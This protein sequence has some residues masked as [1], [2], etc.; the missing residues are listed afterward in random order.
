MSA[1]LQKRVQ[2]LENGRKEPERPAFGVIHIRE[3]ECAGEAWRAEY[4]EAPEPEL[5]V[6]LI[7]FDFLFRPGEALDRKTGQRFAAAGPR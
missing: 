3:N 5:L 4:G 6:G 1:Q 7:A 2:K